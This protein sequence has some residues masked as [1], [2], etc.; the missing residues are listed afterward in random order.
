MGNRKWLGD[1]GYQTYLRRTIDMS[2][3]EKATLFELYRDSARENIR[4]VKKYLE[5]EVLLTRREIFDFLFKVYSVGNMMDATLV[6]ASSLDK[7]LIRYY[8]SAFLKLT[9]VMEEG[10][11]MR[12]VKSFFN[13]CTR[14]AW[15]NGISNG[16]YHVSYSDKNGVI[17]VTLKKG[18]KGVYQAPIEDVDDMVSIGAVFVSYLASE[19]ED[20]DKDKSFV[21]DYLLKEIKRYEDGKGTKVYVDKRKHNLKDT[22]CWVET[23][24]EEG[25]KIVSFKA[26]NY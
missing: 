25:S 6:K 24:K 8:A 1:H 26:V 13:G 12:S 11:S 19:L 23:S 2:K 17:Y 4:T 20:E 16:R 7:C 14:N 15:L 5:K 21:A 3:G 10:Y 9:E 18:R 22:L